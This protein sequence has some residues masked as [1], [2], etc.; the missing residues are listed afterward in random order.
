MTRREDLGWPRDDEQGD[1]HPAPNPTRR[2]S[3]LDAQF[4]AAEHGNAGSHY[5]ALAV[6]S[7]PGR[8]R[9]INAEQMRELLAERIAQCPPLSWQVVTV[10]FGLDQPVF[11][12]TEVDL[13][14][15]VSES[16]LP[17]QADDT[18]LATAVAAMLAAPLPRDKPLWRMH[19]FHGLRGRTAVAI[20]LHHAVVDGLAAKEIFDVLI[21]QVGQSIPASAAVRGELGSTPNRI[22]LAV[23]GLMSI[24]QRQ[25]RVLWSAPRALAHLDQVPTLR[26][27]PGVHTLS[28]YVRRDLDAQRLDAPRTPFNTKLSAARSVAFGTMPFEYV[29][30][31]KRAL[32]V[33]VNDVVIACCAGALRRRLVALGELPDQPLVAYVPTSTRA[34]TG[35]D[36][37]GNAIASIIAPIPTHLSSG[38]AR[39]SFTH[40]TLTRAKIRASKTPPT[41]LSDINDAIPTPFF[42]LAA[43]G[44]SDLLSSSLVRAPVNVIISNVPGS[45]IPLETAGA[46][47]LANYPLSLIFSG[48]ALNMTVVSYQ[49]GLDVGIVAD[50]AA[51]PEA[52]TLLAD[53]RAELSEL[54]DLAD[55][56]GSAN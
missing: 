15:H 7:T 1:G 46:P 53:F 30:A 10:P 39:V 42:G 9:P 27:L 16:T 23:R 4:L 40:E 36:R 37:Y 8:L 29:T 11:V 52:W 48:F 56:G 24:P 14:A 21:D 34:P 13:D 25:A 3:S 31:I 5:C 44:L 35:G 19:V 18:V 51:L 28:R 20:I 49:D 12:A 2:L 47:L 17:A 32:G 22:L 38:G 43:R 50:A 54:H 55:M 45:R 26:S 33:T 41:L 6:Y